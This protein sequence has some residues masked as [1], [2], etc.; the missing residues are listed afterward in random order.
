MVLVGEEDTGLSSVSVE[1]EIQQVVEEEEEEEEP[2][3]EDLEFIAQIKRVL[4]LLKKNHDM[5][6]NEVNF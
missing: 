1:N 3:P 4:E 6:F 5:L 2:T